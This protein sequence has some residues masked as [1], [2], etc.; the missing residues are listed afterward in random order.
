MDSEYTCLHFSTNNPFG[1]E[2]DDLPRLLRNVADTIEALGDIQPMNLIMDVEV[3]EHGF[4]PVV[5]FYYDRPHL[6]LVE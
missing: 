6:Q 2:Q 5:T 1:D 4:L 3:N